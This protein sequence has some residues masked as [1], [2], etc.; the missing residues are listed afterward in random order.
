MRM[1][2]ACACFIAV[3]LLA[4]TAIAHAQVH[5]SATG[6]ARHLWAGAEFSSFDPDYGPD[7]LEGVGLYADY[8][9]TRTF[10]MEGEVRLLDFNKPNGLTEK[11]F[12]GGP[13]YT[14]YRHARFSAYGKGLLGGATVN[15]PFDIGYGSYFAAEAGGGIEYRLLPRVKL[16][17]EY[18]YQFLPGAPGFSLP[19]Y[20]DDGLTPSGINIGLSYRI[21]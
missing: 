17:G 19:G 5:E 3:I 11:T 1:P 18:T 9:I 14:F 7:R 12:L 6:A 16:R 10:A 15:Y 2:Q 8:F 4:S 13:L 20:P 21:F